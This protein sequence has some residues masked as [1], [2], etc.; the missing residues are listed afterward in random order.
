MNITIADIAER[1]KVS[2]MTVSRVLSGKGQVADETAKR[3]KEIIEEL[4]YQP[5]HFARSLSSQKSMI[6]GIVIPKT[7]QLFLDNYLAQV[8]SGIS[9][10]AQ[11]N[12]YHIMLIPYSLDRGEYIN[13]ARGNLVDGMIFI[14]AKEDDKNLDILSDINFPYVLVNHRKINKKTNFVDTENV[15]GAEEAV[16]YLYKKG[17]R[18]IALVA[19]SMDETN[20]RDRLNGYKNALIDLKLPFNEDYVIYCDFNQEKAYLKSAKLFELE[21]PPTAIFCSDDYMA[22]GVISRI[23]EYGLQVPEDIEIVGFDNIEVGA[24]IEPALT[25]VKQ[26]MYEIGIQSAEILLGILNGEMKTPVHRILKT[27]LI[28]R[29]SA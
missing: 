10:I 23:K 16:K 17:H 11:R 7:S 28:I 21:N 27:E 18:K 6:I 14:K 29:N 4:N 26:P 25:T 1:A 13:I 22:L 24:L 19:G 15:M 2:K 8:I 20:G 5:N 9:D 12:D 3:I